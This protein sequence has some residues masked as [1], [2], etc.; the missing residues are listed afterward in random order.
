MGPLLQAVRQGRP[1]ASSEDDD[2]EEL[3]PDDLYQASESQ[4]ELSLFSF[5]A[6]QG[7]TL[8]ANRNDE[9]DIRKLAQKEREMFL[10]SDQVEWEAILGTK[11]VRV[12]VGA[13]AQRLRTKYAD[14]ILSSRMV[15][16]KKPT[17]EIFING[18]PRVVGVY[19]VPRTR[20]LASSS[21][22]LR[23]PRWSR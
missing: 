8:L 9:V 21:P 3:L 17:A 7:W 13:E 20:T 18:R 1:S 10:K 2:S 15:R 12:A 23:L 22:M 16:R 14:R 6:E 19:T 11:A 5:K 4:A